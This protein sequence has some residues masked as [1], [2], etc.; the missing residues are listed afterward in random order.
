MRK[1]RKAHHTRE[2]ERKA[3][4]EILKSKE[5]N[6]QSSVVRNQLKLKRLEKLFNTL[7]EDEDGL[8][9]CH[10]ISINGLENKCI[11]IIT[12][13]LLK[14]EKMDKEIN[15][16]KFIEIAESF[17]K[18]VSVSDRNYLIGPVRKM[19]KHLQ[20]KPT[21]KPEISQR[22]NKIAKYSSQRNS[23]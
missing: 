8:I 3:S 9:S 15:L 5:R 1:S 4:L 18:S 10:R 21:F 23:T 19:F 12:P 11:D 16:K 13:L 14:I 7:D 2:F 22:S 20:E 17:I 6:I